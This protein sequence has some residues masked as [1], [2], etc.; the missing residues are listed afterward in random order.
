MPLPPKTV[1]RPWAGVT[2]HSGE[3]LA[4]HPQGW[5]A[6]SSTEWGFNVGACSGLA[7]ELAGCR[8]TSQRLF[9]RRGDRPTGVRGREG[10]N[11][12]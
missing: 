2:A 6:P 12:N 5:L 11:G 3:A 10:L 8:E 1:N 7:A 4:C 9:L